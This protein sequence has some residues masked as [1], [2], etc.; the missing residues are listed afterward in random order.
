MCNLMALVP[1]SGG[2]EFPVIAENRRVASDFCPWHA[3]C[4]DVREWR[5][6]NGGLSVKLVFGVLLL[7]V[8][9]MPQVL[10]AQTPR[11]KTSVIPG[12][13]SLQSDARLQ[14]SSARDEGSTWI[15]ARQTARLL[16]F[17]DLQ[18]G[19]GRNVLFGMNAVNEGST[20][21]SSGSRPASNKAGSKIDF[22]PTLE[23][24]EVPTRLWR[25]LLIVQH[26]AAVF[27]AWSTRDAIQNSGAHELNPFL[28]PFA[29]S[30]AI[31]AATQVG[32]GLF[33]YLGYRMMRSKKSWARKLWW[34]P[35]FAGTVASIFSGAHNL[36]VAQ[37]KP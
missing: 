22:R 6:I 23:P 18:S 31:Y 14:P 2:L 25:T 36:S 27:D 5:V 1:L 28:R 4:A 29:G 21:I 19:R 3:A 30:G 9:G 10:V 15:G 7:T 32:P 13:S 8:V 12:I 37:G 20:A 17:A 24:Q 11:N 35:Q 26:S 34:L 16:D 33:D